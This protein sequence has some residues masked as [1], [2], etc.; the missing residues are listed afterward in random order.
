MER[1]LGVGSQDETPAPS[2]IETTRREN[3]GVWG[4]TSPRERRV[5]V[6]RRVQRQPAERAARRVGRLE[7][8]A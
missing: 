5:V 4:G 7:R 2:T 8:A 3:D 1:G 6:R